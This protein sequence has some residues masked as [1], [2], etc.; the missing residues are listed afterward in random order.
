MVALAD[1]DTRRGDGVTVINDAYNANP[2]S[3]RFSLDALAAM[4]RGRDQRALAVLGPMNEPPSST[5]P[6]S[7]KVGDTL[8]LEG[9]PGMGA[10][11]ND[12]QGQPSNTGTYC[13][14]VA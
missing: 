14:V 9:V 1:G 2:D 8:S 13:V 5:T 11:G 6:S 7:A 4:A 12:V 3:M 10:T